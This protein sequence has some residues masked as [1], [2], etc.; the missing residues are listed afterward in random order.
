[1]AGRGRGAACTSEGAQMI[2]EGRHPVMVTCDEA[3]PA[4]SIAE[5][6]VGDGYDPA[7]QLWAVVKPTLDGLSLAAMMFIPEAIAAGGTGYGLLDWTVAAIQCDSAIAVGDK[8]ASKAGSW[9]G[10]KATGPL[11]VTSVL[12]G[13]VAV[14]RLVGGAGGG[15]TTV[16]EPG[17]Q[18]YGSAPA[19]AA[20]QLG[21]TVNDVTSMGASTQ[22]G[23]D[24]VPLAIMSAPCGTEQRGMAASGGLTMDTASHGLTAG[25]IVDVFWRDADGKDQ[26]SLGCTVAGVASASVTMTVATGQT[27]LPTTTTIR[28]SVWARAQIKQDTCLMQ[29]RKVLLQEDTYR[30][31]DHLDLAAG[32]FGL[33]WKHGGPVEL[34]TF[35]RMLVAPDTATPLK[36]TGGYF[37]VGV[38]LSAQPADGATVTVSASVLSGS[39]ISLDNAT[40][41][42][43][44]STWSTVQYVGIASTD[45][46][47]GIVRLTATVTTGTDDEYAGLPAVDIPVAPV[48]PAGLAAT[49]NYLSV[50]VGGVSGN[51]FTI[52]VPTAST[53]NPVTVKFTPDPDVLVNGH[54][55]PWELELESSAPQTITITRGT[56]VIPEEA[57]QTKSIKIEFTSGASGSLPSVKAAF[58]PAVSGLFGY[59][60]WAGIAGAMFMALAWAES[61]AYAIRTDY[62]PVAWG[63]MSSAYPGGTSTVS[64]VNMCTMWHTPTPLK[65]W[66]K[67]L[68][69]FPPDLVYSPPVAG[70]TPK[71]IYTSCLQKIAPGQQHVAGLWGGRL[72]VMGNNNNNQ[73]GTYSTL[74]GNGR[75]WIFTL[76]LHTPYTDPVGSNM[77]APYDPC[78][79]VA[80][81]D[82]STAVITK[83]GR[84]FFIGAIWGMQSSPPGYLVERPMPDGVTAV[85]ISGGIDHYL[86]LGDNGHVYSIG[87]NRWRQLGWGDRSS[88][89]YEVQYD[90]I[91]EVPGI[92]NAAQVSAGAFF[93]LALLADGRIMAWGC[94]GTNQCGYAG[95]AGDCVESP[96]YITRST[97]GTDYLTGA[98]YVAAGRNTRPPDVIDPYHSPPDDKATAWAILYDRS[99]VGW[100]NNDFGQAVPNSTESSLTYP[101][102]IRDL[103]PA[104]RVGGNGWFAGIISTSG[105]I[106]TWGMCRVECAGTG[107]HI[108]E[109]NV[110][111]QSVCVG[112]AP[113]LGGASLRSNPPQLIRTKPTIKRVIGHSQSYTTCLI[114]EEDQAFH[115][116]TIFPIGGS[117]GLNDMPFSPP[118]ECYDAMLDQWYRQI[119]GDSSFSPTGLQAYFGTNYVNGISQDS[120]NNASSIANLLPHVVWFTAGCE[121]FFAIT[122]DGKL[123]AWGLN[124]CGQAGLVDT[125]TGNRKYSIRPA[126][127]LVQIDGDWVNA[128]TY[129]KIVR[130]Y[131]GPWYTLFLT[132]NGRLLFCGVTA[133]GIGATGTGHTV[134]KTLT[135]WLETW[136][137][138]QRNAGRQLVDVTLGGGAFQSATGIDASARNGAWAMLR[139]ADDSIYG[140]GSCTSGQLANVHDTSSAPW[141]GATDTGTDQQAYFVTSP[142][143]AWQY[144]PDADPGSQFTP[145]KAK[146][147]G[148]GY[149]HTCFLKA[150]GSVWATGN[151]ST[152]QVGN[153]D[154]ADYGSNC[155]GSTPFAV[156]VFG[157]ARPCG[158]GARYHSVIVDGRVTAYVK[159]DGGSGY[160][161]RFPP[162]VII[163]GGGG[164]GAKGQAVVGMGGIISS[165]MVTNGGYGYTSPPDVA[166]APGD[167]VD[168]ATNGDRLTDCT[169]IGVTAWSALACQKGLQEVVTEIGVVEDAAL[170]GT[171]VE[172]P[173]PG[174]CAVQ[175]GLS[176]QFL[177]LGQ[178]GFNLTWRDADG[179]LRSRLNCWASGVDDETGTMTFFGGV[180]DDWPTGG[181]VGVNGYFGTA[182]V[183][184]KEAS[185]KPGDKV[186]LAWMWNGERTAY[187]WTITTATTGRLIV[188]HGLGLAMHDLLPVSGTVA[189]RWG[190]AVLAWGWGP[191]MV[192][193]VY[194]ASIVGAGDQYYPTAINLTTADERQCY[195]CAPDMVA[196]GR[197]CSYMRSVSGSLFG[198]G[199]QSDVAAVVESLQP[200]HMGVGYLR[201]AI[202]SGWR[203]VVLGG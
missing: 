100:G 63:D 42:F 88:G 193:P 117:S 36:S 11:E 43:T 166:F 35:K 103:P 41:A 110:L 161:S 18:L 135:P 138:D 10:T 115:W 191:D 102:R 139:L 56:N 92:T 16:V 21:K 54:A 49:F 3:I 198:F 82:T 68:P 121:N 106:H 162:K 174:S 148:C 127:V 178:D 134:V 157:P 116:G 185:F 80:C 147:V 152:G 15:G 65:Q 26:C 1:M 131:P 194:V 190:S 163:S 64:D 181:T 112:K 81:T 79:D 153:N 113:F 19:G 124:E 118:S 160:D 44:S 58:Q 27:A 97:S 6:S 75:L 69:I 25:Q 129:Y 32:S 24:G 76:Q 167:T 130:V 78:V 203:H 184:R 177:D 114:T 132:A 46:T 173:D 145:M 150:D 149:A 158:T 180:G 183:L 197:Y 52:A 22:T 84:F 111:G 195:A 201:G 40:L 93:S 199:Y 53:S 85:A 126:E 33:A 60:K 45:T 133:Y 141:V 165:I 38:R 72:Y 101:T 66:W 171:V 125:T 151:N 55:D 51:T 71:S 182:L 146:Q 39:G 57:L 48:D 109:T 28:V 99:V 23:S 122:R 67:T 70:A 8:I 13:N 62:C 83:S 73:C 86:I 186:D 170:T 5:V 179:K 34:T 98:I 94:N 143:Q 37:L 192:Y 31:G 77:T 128:G 136:T 90:D 74:D 175:C 104:W 156:P 105:Q 154:I 108:G 196:A 89:G 169:S 159:D 142:Q 9:Q 155:A 47:A 123:W 12:T 164:A 91:G 119:G 30:T 200:N 7:E 144:D 137:T 59:V 20:V 176:G 96:A 95:G 172:S 87:A 2:Y 4:N 17:V 120:N 140:I 188:M 50:K 29:P 189:I 14:V 202:P 107:G 61:A 168:A 187:T